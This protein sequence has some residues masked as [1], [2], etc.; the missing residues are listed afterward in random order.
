V[1]PLVG[2]G[3]VIRKTIFSSCRSYRYTLWREWH[4][5]AELISRGSGCC[6]AGSD[7]ECFWAECPQRRD[8]EPARSGRRCPR[9]G[10]DAYL[11]VIGLNPSTADET[12]DDPTI[13][14]CIDFAKRWKFGALCMTNLFA[15]RDTKPAQMKKATDP[16]GP[17]NDDHLKRLAANAGLILAAWGTH[18]K[19]LNRAAAVLS[20]MPPIYRLRLNDDGSPEHPL[21]VPANTPPVLF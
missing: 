15:W 4:Q 13:R 8:G 6:R 19:H 21:Y 16:V 10:E 17:D 7:G 20:M 5:D 12:E 2:G 11:M 18:G 14:R 9:D 3:N 1:P